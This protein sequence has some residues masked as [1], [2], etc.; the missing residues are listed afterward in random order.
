MVFGKVRIKKHPDIVENYT[1]SEN[2][3]NAH[4]PRG[5]FD[6]A[7]VYVFSPTDWF[8][9]RVIGKLWGFGTGMEMNP[10][11]LFS[12]WCRLQSLFSA[13]WLREKKYSGLGCW[14][15]AG[16]WWR[17]R[18]GSPACRGGVDSSHTIPSSFH[19][20][21]GTKLVPA[22]PSSAAQLQMEILK[23]G[24]SCPCYSEILPCLF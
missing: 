20:G 19:W 4:H 10:E 22:H 15:E 13:C 3:P 17:C 8:L 9:V 23:T 18:P 11:D 21:E 16:E 12:F 24:A 6:N 14:E 2:I 5:T 1:Q 7:L